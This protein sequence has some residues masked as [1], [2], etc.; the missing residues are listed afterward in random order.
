MSEQRFR[1]VEPAPIPGD[2]FPWEPEPRP[3]TG[4]GNPAA[5]PGATPSPASPAD[6]FSFDL[7]GGD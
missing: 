4:P 3:A 6:P 7:G 2:P 5:S 1:A